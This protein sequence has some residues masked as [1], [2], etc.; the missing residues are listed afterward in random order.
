MMDR[1]VLLYG[2]DSETRTPF[3]LKM[4]IIDYADSLDRQWLGE[5]WYPV[6]KYVQKSQLMESPVIDP[7]DLDLEPCHREPDLCMSRS[8]VR[9]G[10]YALLDSGATHVLLPGHTLPKGARQLEVTI[11]LAVGKE[12]ARCWRNEVY[13]ED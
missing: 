8:Q 9:D 7:Q 10:A 4:K 6:T 2:H 12:K 5:V 1:Q 13:A 3:S 11:N